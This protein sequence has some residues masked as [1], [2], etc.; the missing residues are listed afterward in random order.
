MSR[1]SVDRWLANIGEFHLDDKGVCVLEADQ[2]TS[3]IV[4]VPQETAGKVFF[5]A[6]IAAV[7]DSDQDGL[8][9]F[10][11]EL[12]LS[13]LHSGGLTFALDSFSG[14]LLLGLAKECE[15]L[16]EVV[17]ANILSNIAVLA[18]QFAVKV[19]EFLAENDGEPVLPP[20]T[21]KDAPAGMVRV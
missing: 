21:G 5:H 9:R 17:F 19:A 7:G 12:N 2:G 11:L 4:E 3:V 14:T 6:P 15:D 20:E 16:D 18:Q 10:V 13:L 8:F 1:E